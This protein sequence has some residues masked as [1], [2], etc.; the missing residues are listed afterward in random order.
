VALGAAG[1]DTPQRY[2]PHFAYGGVA[3]DAYLWR[4]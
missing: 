3:M 4:A 1:D 2:R